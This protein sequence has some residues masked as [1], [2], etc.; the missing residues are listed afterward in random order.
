VRHRR[1]FGRFEMNKHHV[2]RKREDRILVAE[3]EVEN[4]PLGP[5]VLPRRLNV[6]IDGYL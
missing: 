5:Y 6:R 3:K 4:H 1:H 2:D